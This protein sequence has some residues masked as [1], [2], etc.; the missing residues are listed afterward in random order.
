MGVRRLHLSE[1]CLLL[2]L[3][4]IIR[5]EKYLFAVSRSS[6]K[7]MKYDIQKKVLIKI[8]RCGYISALYIEILSLGIHIC[9]VE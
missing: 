1:E 3:S 7:T 2:S 5:P 6:K 8:P 9:F 4:G